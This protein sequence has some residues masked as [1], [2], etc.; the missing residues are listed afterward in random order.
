M[1]A[2]ASLSAVTLPANATA[3][4]Q[5]I[6]KQQLDAASSGGTLPASAT[7]ASLRYTDWRMRPS[8]Q[9]LTNATRGDE[10]ALFLVT[11]SAGGSESATTANGRLEVAWP[12]SSNAALYIQQPLTSRV[13]R[14]GATVGF[15]PTAGPT[16]ASFCLACWTTDQAT[17][18]VSEASCHLFVTVYGWTYQVVAGGQFVTIASGSYAA[19]LPMDYSEL[20]LEVVIEGATAYIFLPD[21]ST[22]VATDSR[23][24]SLYGYSPCWEFF[25][26]SGTTTVPLA[27]YE[28]WADNDPQ[29]LGRLSPGGLARTM[30]LYPTT[31]TVI[32]ALGSYVPTSETNAAAG[33]PSRRTLGTGATQ[34]AAGN[35]THTPAS[36]GAL[37]TTDRGAANGV[38]PLD[39]GGYVQQGYLPVVI[40]PPITVAY[41]ATIQPD[42][43]L[44]T[45]YRTTLTANITLNNPTSAQDGQ[46]VVHEF[47]NSTAGARTVSL[48]TLFEKLSTIDATL[49]IPAG[50]VGFLTYVW[51]TPR[52]AFTVLGWD[53]TA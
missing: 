47:V 38:A 9:A 26:D 10:G 50:A 2:R 45:H 27:M 40:K 7:G 23:I 18:G 6:P 41:A 14:I 1:S 42:I 48:G 8:G 36:I 17:P 35:H 16:S 15:G 3:A 37:S 12:P 22:G 34:A 13:R 51:S 31:Q 4:L 29:P 46:R 20:R 43:A 11:Q 28:T 24:A 49:T 53:Y 33:T 5:A 52:V 39:G 32:S 25:R 21:G 44:G 19:P 30:A